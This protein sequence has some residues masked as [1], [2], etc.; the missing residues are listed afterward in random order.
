MLCDERSARYTITLGPSLRKRLKVRCAEDETTI[1]EVIR[2][3]L[4]QYVA[5]PSSAG[6]ATPEAD[7]RPRA[8]KG[9]AA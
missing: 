8:S 7:V 3:A 1:A 9:R 4:K 6:N 2:A 5:T